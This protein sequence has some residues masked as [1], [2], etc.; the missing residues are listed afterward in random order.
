M[1]MKA[2]VLDVCGANQNDEGATTTAA[3]TTMR[4]QT[5][6]SHGNNHECETTA[7]ATTTAAI[8]HIGR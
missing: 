2:Q 7:T 8:Q 3:E 5:T 6:D 4:V 1:T